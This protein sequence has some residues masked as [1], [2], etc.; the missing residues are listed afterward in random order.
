MGTMRIESSIFLQ[1]RQ[2]PPLS[3]PPL[4]LKEKMDGGVGIS[5]NLVRWFPWQEDGSVDGM[6]RPDC[7]REIQGIEIVDEDLSPA[8]CS[9]GTPKRSWGKPGG[10]N[11]KC[12]R[13]GRTRTGLCAG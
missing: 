9:C 5:W 4:D 7:S 10:A 2:P 12:S 13:A 8:V 11:R 1:I 6:E 3:S